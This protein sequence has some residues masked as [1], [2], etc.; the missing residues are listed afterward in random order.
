MATS[1]RSTSKPA[2][3]RK[4][5]IG[6]GY[7][8]RPGYVNVDMDPAAEPD[9]LV[10]PDDDSAIPRQHFDSVL[11]KDVLEHI[12]RSKTLS[13]LLNW[14]DYLRHG[15]TLDVQTSSIYG[16]TDLMRAQST[17]ENQY[18]MTVCLFGN[19]AHPG[20]FH[21]TGFTE[22]TLRVHLLSAGFEPGPIEMI[23][24]WMYKLTAR[25]V[26]DWTATLDD[27]NFVTNTF[28]AAFG[29]EPEEHHIAHFSAID[30]KTAAHEIW[31]SLERL[32]VTARK[33]GL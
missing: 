9:I 28:L 16:V 11:A 7:D 31:S 25:K 29:R 14:A 23:D 6:C 22:T 15:G 33:H 17:F 4:L 18:G 3:S 19:Q 12:P 27:K 30:R 2:L 13:A 10:T 32:Y 26:E 1:K 20:D 21:Y 5:N 8:K 24:G